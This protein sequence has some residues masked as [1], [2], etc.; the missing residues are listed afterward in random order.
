MESTCL[1]CDAPLAGEYCEYCANC[2]QRKTHRNPTFREFLGEAF[3]ELFEWDGKIPATLRAL[4]ARPGLLTEDFLAGRRARW[5][6]PLRVYLICSVSYFLVDPAVTLITGRDVE[7]ASAV[8]F[9]DESGERVSLADLTPEDRAALERSRIFGRLGADRLERIQANSGAITEVVVDAIPKAMFALMPLFALLTWSLWRSDGARFPSHLYFTLHLHA[10]FFA[11]LVPPQLINALGWGGA[12]TVLGW[13]ALIYSTWYA[14]VAM[15]R[16]LGG[17]TGPLI[18]RSIVLGVV[19]SFAMLA[20]VLGI[21]VVAM[22][23]F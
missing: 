1:N 6:S 5:I 7:R 3:R 15:K 14:G 22:L 21:T 17:A 13:A 18:A 12:A 2:G 20:V 11:A 19:Y 4:L 10:A 23:Q 8:K 16:V 9:I